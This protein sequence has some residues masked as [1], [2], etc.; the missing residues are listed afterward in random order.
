MLKQILR[1]TKTKEQSRNLGFSPGRI[2]EF[3]RQIEKEKVTN[4]APGGIA[5]CEAAAENARVGNTITG[6]EDWAS[7]DDDDD[8]AD[9]GND[10]DDNDDDGQE[11]DDILG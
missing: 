1:V 6:K 10:E 8:D 3:V 2:L 7:D 9:D 5:V 4:L 11:D